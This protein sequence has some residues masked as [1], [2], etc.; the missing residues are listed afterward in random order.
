MQSPMRC[1]GAQGSSHSQ[2]QSAGSPVSQSWSQSESRPD[3]GQKGAEASYCGSMSES[4]W[5]P[6]KR[7]I[8]SGVEGVVT[9]RR[10]KP[11]LPDRV[12]K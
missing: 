6:R 1:M 11:K 8:F 2:S 7:D 12:E 4:V 3:S 5:S 10:S 9:R